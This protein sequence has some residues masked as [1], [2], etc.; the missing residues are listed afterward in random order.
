MNLCIELFFC[1]FLNFGVVSL[2]S[3][4]IQSHLSERNMKNSES[5]EMSKVEAK[6]RE[7]CRSR[8]ET[9]NVLG[10]G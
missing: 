2:L 6:R 4:M 5:E 8:G 3:T 1:F 9:Q 10:F 7:C